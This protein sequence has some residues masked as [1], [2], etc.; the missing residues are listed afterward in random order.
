MCGICGAVALNTNLVKS[1]REKIK[2]L[3]VLNEERGSAS[4][5]LFDWVEAI[6]E[7][8]DVKWTKEKKLS[9][10]VK[11][12][13]LEETVH[14]KTTQHPYD[15][16]RHE[17]ELI[18]FYRWSERERDLTTIVGHTRAPTTGDITKKNAHPFRF[19]NLIGVHNGTITGEFEGRK[20]FGTDSEAL[21]SLISKKG[22][23]D[24]IK[25]VHEQSMN[26]AAA[27]VWIDFDAD[28]LNIWRNHMRP[29]HYFE[30][31]GTRYFSSEAKH[32]RYALDLSAT[33]EIKEFKPMTLYTKRLRDTGGFKEETVSTYQTNYTYQHNHGYE[34]WN[35]RVQGELLPNYHGISKSPTRGRPPGP[36]PSYYN[37]DSQIS[38]AYHSYWSSVSLD[39]ITDTGDFHFSDYRKYYDLG[40]GRYYAEF[41][42]RILQLWKNDPKNRQ[43]YLDSFVQRWSL[44]SSK[45]KADEESWC[46]KH[47]DIPTPREFKDTERTLALRKAVISTSSEEDEEEESKFVTYGRHKRKGSR[48]YVQNLLDAGCACGCLRQPSVEE[49]VLWSDDTSFICASCAL[50]ATKLRS[51]LANKMFSMGAIK[52]FLTKNQHVIN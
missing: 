14:Y 49:G 30:T 36:V 24:A 27:L 37:Q 41:Q 46:F 17:F 33:A 11:Q 38:G 44:M 35:K 51:H 52:S 9:S 26:M 23:K 42:F 22:F 29:L 1:E 40:T 2:R 12:M 43:K 48:A 28:T 45:E 20:D 47:P 13:A 34:R 21:Y 18:E 31:G 19:D 8:E 7:N 39:Q 3:L 4:T 50:E 10:K 32:L 6:D 15:F 25:Q 5:G 16:V